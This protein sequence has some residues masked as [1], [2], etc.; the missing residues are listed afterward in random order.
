MKI[1]NFGAKNGHQGWNEFN[2]SVNPLLRAGHLRLAVL[3]CSFNSCFLAGPQYKNNLSLGQ[4]C[5]N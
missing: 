3:S 4:A 1:I 2:D 5:F